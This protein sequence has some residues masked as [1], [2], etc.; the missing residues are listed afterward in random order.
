MCGLCASRCPAQIVHFNVGIL[1]RRLY[2]RHLLP[3]ARHLQNRV[4]EVE[5]GKFAAEMAELVKVSK[6]TLRNLYAKRV[7]ED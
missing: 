2:A 4:A 5:S 3:P 7:I 1:A 6:E